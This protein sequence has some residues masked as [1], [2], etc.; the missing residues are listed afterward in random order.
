MLEGQVLEGEVL[1]GEVLDKASDA[2]PQGRKA[3]QPSP[4]DIGA[5]ITKALKAA[6]LIR[7]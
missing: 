1:E 5:V 7:T 6:G 4:T 3:P 2:G